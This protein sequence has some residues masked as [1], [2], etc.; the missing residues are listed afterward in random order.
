MHFHLRVARPVSD[1][2]RAADMYCRGLGF[3][4]LGEFENHRGFDGVMV[5]ETGSG[6][7]FEFTRSRAHAL[8]PTPTAEDL[9]VFY[10]PD[11]D[12][13]DVLCERMLTAGFEPVAAF[14]PYWDERGRTFADPDGYRTVIQ[15]ARWSND[16]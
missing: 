4:V 13:W 14:N 12:A 8:T 15:R 1:L 5:G 11:D 10:V 3:R 16:A 6:F 2:A 7:H 9:A